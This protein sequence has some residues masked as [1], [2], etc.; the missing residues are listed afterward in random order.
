MRKSHLIVLSVILIATI[1]SAAMAADSQPVQAPMISGMWNLPEA[2]LR[3]TNAGAVAGS[4][5]AANRRRSVIRGST[6]S[7]GCWVARASTRSTIRRLSLVDPPGLVS[8]SS[9]F[10]AAIASLNAE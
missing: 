7:L 10:I 5:S 9:S 1:S 4:A 8:K 6:S 3:W 2:P